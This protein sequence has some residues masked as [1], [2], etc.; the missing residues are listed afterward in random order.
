MA[1]LPLS[2]LGATQGGYWITL[3]IT[4]KAGGCFGC[5]ETNHWMKNCPWAD[6]AAPKSKCEGKRRLALS[7]TVHNLGYPT[8]CVTH[9]NNF[10]G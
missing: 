8:Y 4:V 6:T 3:H 2:V 10:N 1:T 9:V 5:G 7:K